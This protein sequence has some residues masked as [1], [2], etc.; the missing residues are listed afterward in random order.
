[1]LTGSLEGDRNVNK[2]MGRKDMIT[3]KMGGKKDGNCRQK[4]ERHT[5]EKKEVHKDVWNK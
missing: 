5:C 3:G 1:M 2:D 4:V